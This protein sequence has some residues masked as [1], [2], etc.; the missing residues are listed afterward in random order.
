MEHKSQHYVP[1]AYLAGFV[2]PETP[3]HHTPYLWVYE[4]DKDA[5]YR[6]AP[7]NV[8]EESFYYSFQDERGE[9]QH[10]M[11][12]GLSNIEGAGIEV[13]RALV[14]GRNPNDL[15]RQQRIDLAVFLGFMAGRVPARRDHIEAQVGEFA[16]LVMRV[17]ASRREY[18]HR[19]FREAMAERDREWTEEEVEAHRQRVLAGDTA[20]FQGTPATSLGMMIEMAP[21]EGQYV[22]EFP[23]RVLET[24]EGEA[25]LTSDNPL[26]KVSTERLPGFLGQATGWETPWMEATFPLGPS[27]CLLISQHHPPGREVLSED[28]VREVNYR[29]AAHA[30][31][32]VYASGERPLE[33]V[34]SPP[35]GAT[36]WRPVTDATWENASSEE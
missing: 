5:P 4:A 9:L 1:R 30:A 17:A 12:E 14:D 28:R 29:T 24:P 19:T 16:D 18:F 32:E 34:F 13:L 7:K 25:F 2:D 22:L 21:V 26:V 36:W 15:T 27:A 23:W 11:E 20:E 35:P 33:E 10:D 3:D 31:D 6:K 8:A